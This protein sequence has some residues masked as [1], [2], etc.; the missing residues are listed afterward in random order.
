[1]LLC[2]FINEQWHL[3]S[4]SDFSWPIV[5]PLGTPEEVLSAILPHQHPPGVVIP[6]VKQPRWVG[7]HTPLW[8]PPHGDLSCLLFAD[9]FPA[10]RSRKWTLNVGIIVHLK[11]FTP[12]QHHIMWQCMTVS[13]CLM[14]DCFCTLALHKHVTNPKSI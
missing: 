12:S 3:A 4:W 13:W 10:T 6:S 7:V 5:S 11:W 2:V 9:E 14:H 8:T 1:M